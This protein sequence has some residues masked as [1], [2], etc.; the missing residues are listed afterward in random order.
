MPNAS[1][2]ERERARLGA[3]RA[4]RERGEPGDTVGAV[5]R[6]GQGGI[7]VGSSTGGRPGQLP[8]RVGDA[9]VPGCGFY[10]DDRV[11][12]YKRAISVFQDLT[13]SNH[14][15]LAIQTGEDQ[16]AIIDQNGKVTHTITGI[17]SKD[18]LIAILREL[19]LEA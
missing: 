10:A 9:P 17:L 3:W 16:L 2:V 12:F 8:G 19:G 1:V 14:C 13:G 15:F 7:A 5:A 4:G 11:A 6:D 18:R